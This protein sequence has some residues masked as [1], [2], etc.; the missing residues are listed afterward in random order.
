MVE[1]NDF[2]IELPEFLVQLTEGF[3]TQTKIANR[4]WTAL[5]LVCLIAIM[6]T[7]STI[8]KTTINMPFGLGDVQR[9]DFYPLATLFISILI[10]GFCS[11]SFQAIRTRSLIH[12]AIESLK[13]DI[14]LPGNI[15]LQDVFDIINH[16][17]IF[18]VAPIAQVLQGSFQFY[19]ESKK[20]PRKRVFL[21]TIYYLFLKVITFLVMYIFPAYGL[22]NSFLSGGLSSWDADPWKIHVIF[23][24]FPSI[25]ALL[26]L[27]Q[28]FVSDSLYVTRALK[29]IS[30]RWAG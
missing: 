6:P 15:H 9:P 23:F 1:K 4:F 29:R 28:L 20:C 30:A 14:V 24:W 5:A 22:V 26:I 3:S 12:R 13:R 7:A 11:A 16:P 25:M 10:I 19:P 21:S 8:D 27:F 17:S 18:R 2:N